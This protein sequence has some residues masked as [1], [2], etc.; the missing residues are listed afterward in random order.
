MVL[1]RTIAPLAVAALWE[2]TGDY[3]A[4]IWLLVG[5]TTVGAAAFWLA[6]TSS[7]LPEGESK[8]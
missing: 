8:G 7:P 2:R 1:P 6:S 4:V 5:T 3:D